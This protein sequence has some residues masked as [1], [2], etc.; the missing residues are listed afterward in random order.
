MN[1]RSNLI[2]LGIFLVGGIPL[3]GQ[4]AGKTANEQKLCALLAGAEY[5]KQ[6]LM[7]AVQAQSTLAESCRTADEND[8]IPNMLIAAHNYS[9]SPQTSAANAI[10]Q[11]MPQNATEMEAFFEFTHAKGNDSLLPLYEKFYL[12]L[13]NAAKTRSQMLPRIL[14]VAVNFDTKEWPNYDETDFSVL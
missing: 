7:A 11:S 2:F 1:F 12:E 3:S 9:L 13:F 8:R 10:L 6:K 4:Q 5:C 14:D